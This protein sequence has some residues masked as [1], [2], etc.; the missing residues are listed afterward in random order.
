MQLDSINYE[1]SG[2]AYILAQSFGDLRAERLGL[3]VSGGGRHGFFRVFRA[4][5]SLGRLG[6]RV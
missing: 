1:V 4:Y 3:G 5:S 2:P 6:F